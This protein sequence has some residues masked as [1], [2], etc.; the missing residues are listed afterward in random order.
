VTKADARYVKNHLVHTIT[1]ALASNYT[2]VGEALFT[3]AHH[4]GKYF[5]YLGFR[6]VKMMSDEARR[7]PR[8]Q[9]NQ[10]ESIMATD[11]SQSK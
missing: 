11:A 2:P 3:F 9:S 4:F 6:D 5:R 1:P 10:P 8:R 7:E